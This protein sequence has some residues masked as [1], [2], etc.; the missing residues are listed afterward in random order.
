MT[1]KILYLQSESTD[2]TAEVYINDKNNIVFVINNNQLEEYYRYS[3]IAL[4]K[5]D[6]IE[7]R[8]ELTKLIKQL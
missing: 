3:L 2:D 6:A 7:L 8:N 1:N 5:D 4:S